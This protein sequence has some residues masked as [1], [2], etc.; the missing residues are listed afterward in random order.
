MTET[1]ASHQGAFGEF[2]LESFGF[3][4]DFGSRAS[5]FSRLGGEMP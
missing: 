1:A 3:V 5:D 4:S 2:E